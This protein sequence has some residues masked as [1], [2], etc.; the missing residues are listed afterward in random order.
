M[1]EA[2]RVAEIELQRMQM[3]TERSKR[4][5]EMELAKLQHQ[6]AVDAKRRETEKAKAE[7]DRALRALGQTSEW[8][9]LRAATEAGLTAEQYVELQRIRAL[10]AMNPARVSYLP[11]SAHPYMQLMAKE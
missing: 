1:Q 9:D 7:H 10:A 5:Q 4:A 8:A 6:A 2:R 3:E 11:S